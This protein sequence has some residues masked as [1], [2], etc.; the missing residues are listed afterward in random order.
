M[1][2]ILPLAL[3]DGTSIYTSGYSC[4][5][6]YTDKEDGTYTF[7]D[8]QKGIAPDIMLDKSK[9]YDDEAIYNVIHAQDQSQGQE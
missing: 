2:S 9:F 7:H 5:T 1:C 4:M 8:V 6:Y 3:I